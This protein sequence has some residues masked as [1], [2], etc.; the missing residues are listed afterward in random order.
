M[1]ARKNVR[2]FDIYTRV[3]VVECPFSEADCRCLEMQLMGR[4]EL[5]VIS[6]IVGN[7]DVINLKMAIDAGEVSIRDFEEYCH[8]KNES[9][10]LC[11]AELA[12]EFLEV[13]YGKKIAW[14]HLCESE[15]VEYDFGLILDFVNGFDCV[16]IDQEVCACVLRDFYQHGRLG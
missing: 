7:A 12:S 3:G 5:I 14:V 8:G 15:F 13:F 10:D 16:L 9:F 4:V 2:E 6:Q 1:M 11:N